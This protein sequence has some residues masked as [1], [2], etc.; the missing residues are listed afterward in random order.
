MTQRNAWVLFV[1]GGIGCAVGAA[2]AP[3]AFAAAGS[4]AEKTQWTPERIR[5]REQWLERDWQHY[6][7]KWLQRINEA[8]RATLPITRRLKAGEPIRVVIPKGHGVLVDLK[9]AGVEAAATALSLFEGKPRNDPMGRI[10][11]LVQKK[12]EHW[13]TLYPN[14]NQPPAAEVVVYVD[15]GA[16]IAHLRAVPLETADLARFPEGLA[17]GQQPQGSVMNCGPELV[18]QTGWPQEAAGCVDGVSR[19]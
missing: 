7:L 18:Y 19:S 8:P 9:Y 6:Q 1:I 16:V 2:Y 15:K 14:G 3:K 13:I 5:E 11:R 12:G 10:G 4:A 17:L